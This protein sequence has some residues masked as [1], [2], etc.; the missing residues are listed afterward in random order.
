MLPDW[1]ESNPYQ[2]LLADGIEQAGAEVEFSSTYKRVLPI[3]RDWQSA[4]RGA[5]VYHLHWLENYVRFEDLPRRV[6]YT[7]KLLLDLHLL[8]SKG[9]KLVWTIHNLLP[10][11]VRYPSFERW[12]CRQIA[13]LADGLIVHSASAR[14]AV[15]QTY[16]L[17]PSRL[18]IIPH[19]HYRECYGTMPSKSEARTRIGLPFDK[20]LLFFGFARPYKGLEDLI[21][22]WKRRNK[23]V[24]DGSAG[25]VIA[26]G[27]I[28]PDYRETIADLV[29]DDDSIWTHLNRIPDE[30]IPEFYA[31]ADAVA[32]P[33]RR[34]LTS[35]SLLLALGFGKPILGPDRE[36]LQEIL[37]GCPG[38]LY[39]S[40]DPVEGITGAINTF[41]SSD[42]A[43]MEPA[44]R[45]RAEAFDWEPIGR[46]TVALYTALTSGTTHAN[47]ARQRN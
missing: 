17:D 11:E 15:A 2:Q 14:D 19:G 27:V 29:G 8:K 6:V 16:G 40:D 13:A 28:N 23:T 33:F 42:C 5:D 20:V 9:V 18:T 32:L 35:G 25:L 46:H 1:R 43:A 12:M 38:F 39:P 45:K 36:L 24:G 30:Q 10:H 31:A 41:L 4:G 26:G 37:E 47:T 34:I 7:A 3:F 22:A 21:S 44:V